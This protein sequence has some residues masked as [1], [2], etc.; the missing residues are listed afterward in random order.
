MMKTFI[1][2][3]DWKTQLSILNLISRFNAVPSKTGLHR[4]LS[5]KESACQ[6]SRQDTYIRSLGQEDPLEQ[7]TA[8][9]SSSL[10]WKSP[11]TE[12]PGR[13]QS[14]GLQSQTC[15]RE[16]THTSK[17]QVG[18]FA[19]IDQLWIQQKDKRTIRLF[20]C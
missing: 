12:E 14:M 9:R 19:D 4:R 1:I 13:L 3:I 16:S 18:V 17:M 15:L 20:S 8:S 2:F 5:G 10:A 7:E 6:C 11:W